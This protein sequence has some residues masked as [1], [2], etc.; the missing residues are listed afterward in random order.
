MN[1]ISAI[2]IAKNEEE[3]I[4]DCLDSLRFCSEKIVVDSGSE[5]RTVE[6]AHR[7]GAKVYS[8]ETNDFSKLRNFGLDKAKGDWILYV[9]ADERVSSKLREEVSN[10]TKMQ[11]RF[12]GMS[13]YYLKRKNFYLG[14]HEWPHIEKLERLF[15]RGVL[16]GWKGRL[17]ESPIFEGEAGELDG[18]L[19][20][21]THRDLTSMLNK[22]IDW[23][24]V[25]AELRFR[26]GH[27]NVTWWRLA[28]VMVTAFFDYFIRQK[29]WKAGAVG[30]IESIYQS[31]SIFVT[32]ARLW[33]MQNKIKTQ[34]AKV[35][36]T[37]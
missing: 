35:K 23:S 19:V 24:R 6:I 7:F 34:N 2:I 22:T 30:I 26:A 9:D 12:K 36:T 18:F 11:D 33:E 31:F 10:L 17:H 16:K 3:M 25:E 1:K 13:A 14:N 27:P 4:A 32:Y 29:G 28:R 21:Y 15:K 37:N 5:D 8:L 20:H